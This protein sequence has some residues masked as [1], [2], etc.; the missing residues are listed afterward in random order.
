MSDNQLLDPH[1][2]R[3]AVSWS[4]SWFPRSVPVQHGLPSLRGVGAILPP[5][6]SYFAALR[7][8]Q[9]HRSAAPVPLAL[10]L[11][12]QRRLVLGP[13]QLRVHVSG[14]PELPG[15]PVR[16]CHGHR[17]RRPSRRP[18]PL[19]VS[20]LLSLAGSH[21]PH[22][23][24]P[25]H[26]ASTRRLPDMLQGSLPACWAQLWPDGIRTRWTTH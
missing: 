2:G 5:L 16:T 21:D 23:R 7:L 26:H 20:R 4:R 18:C 15:C 1:S 12:A 8:P 11:L 19:T 10:D 3:S 13:R 24:V 6:L 9:A 25:M 22:A 14:Y 17:P